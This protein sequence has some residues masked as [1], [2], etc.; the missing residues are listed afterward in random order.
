MLLCVVFLF[1]QTNAK[2]PHHDDLRGK[3][4]ICQNDSYSIEDWGIKFL[5]EN[6]VIMY[7]L[8]KSIYEIYQYQR[9]YRTNIRNIIITK[10]EQIEFVINR[11]RLILGNKKCKTVKGDPS[12]LLQ[13]RIKALKKK[14]Q[15]RN[16]I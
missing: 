13:N 15:D 7:S 6:R 5:K 14:R 1:N 3:N 16:K 10:D 9:D 2:D 4:L 11:K 12:I 8:N